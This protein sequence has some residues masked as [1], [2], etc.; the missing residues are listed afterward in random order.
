MYDKGEMVA[1]TFSGTHQFLCP[2]IAEGSIDFLGAKG[3]YGLKITYL[4]ERLRF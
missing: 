3:T 2:E 1:Q 4:Y